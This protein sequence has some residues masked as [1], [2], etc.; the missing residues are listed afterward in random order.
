MKISEVVSSLNK[1]QYEHGDIEVELLEMRGDMCIPK[2]W[3]D[4]GVCDI[5][6]RK[7][8]DI[9]NVWERND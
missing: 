3:Y 5:D 7:F 9:S 8:V 4:I 2:D 6:G 1:I